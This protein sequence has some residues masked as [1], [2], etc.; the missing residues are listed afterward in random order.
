MYFPDLS[1]QPNSKRPSLSVGWL[2]S[3]HQYNQGAVTQEFVER[4]LV[5]CTNPVFITMGIHECEFCQ[6]INGSQGGWEYGSG[7]IWVFGSDAAHYVAPDMIYHYVVTHQ[8]L[9]PEEFIQAVLVCPL[10][11]TPE[12][13]A[14]VAQ[15]Q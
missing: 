15:A 4:L 13:Q 9:P 12:Y 5:F 2:D 7:E 11:D 6:E 10:P 8:Y 14:L 3:S 1:P